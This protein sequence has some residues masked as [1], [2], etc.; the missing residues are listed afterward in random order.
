MPNVSETSR[1]QQAPVVADLRKRIADGTYGP[2]DRLPSLSAICQ[3]Y[4]V[5]DRSARMCLRQL[6]VEGL[7]EIRERRGAFVRVNE[8]TPPGGTPSLGPPRGRTTLATR[9]HAP[10]DAPTA[11][12]EGWTVACEDVR[13]GHAP[14][15][16]ALAL[17]IP[18]EEAVMVRTRLL[19]DASGPVA[20][21]TSWTRTEI[22]EGTPLA[23]PDP[24]PVQGPWPEALRRHGGA[25][26]LVIAVHIFARRA[27]AHE[28]RVL[29]I[30]RADPVLIHCE[31]AAT[32]RGPI[33][34]TRTFSPAR[35]VRYTDTY[36]PT[37]RR[38][39]ET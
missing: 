33:D 22:A 1:M 29:G 20:I 12:D 5:G 19:R 13:R 4:G 38:P 10:A 14:P 3:V 7:V 26:D 32:P 37:P 28:A 34:V 11:G 24:D 30:T 23:D 2:G 27:T 25:K 15:D 8:C 6:E 21:R 16:V 31:T 17:A 9:P 18:G 39:A 35:D 36:T